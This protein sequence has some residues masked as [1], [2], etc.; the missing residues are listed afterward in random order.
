[1]DISEAFLRVTPENQTNIQRAMAWWK[2]VGI[3]STSD[4]V[5][6]Q[7]DYRRVRGLIDIRDPRLDAKL[8]NAAQQAHTDSLANRVSGLHDG[9]LILFG[10]GLHEKATKFFR[11]IL[12]EGIRHSTA[13]L[14]LAWCQYL[15]NREDLARE[16]LMKNFSSPDILGMPDRG[17]LR[18]TGLRILD[19]LGARVGLRKAAP[20]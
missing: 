14:Y 20:Q 9:A 10:V 1:D 15:G 8:T 12:D 3:S 6:F 16:T 7:E 2:V 13:A 18:Q 17:P 5:A 19:E 4:P 11:M